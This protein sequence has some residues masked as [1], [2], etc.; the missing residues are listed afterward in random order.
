MNPNAC[1]DML[2]TL[3]VV[4][5][6]FIPVNETIASMLRNRFSAD[7]SA[8]IEALEFARVLDFLDKGDKS[9]TLFL[10]TN[11]AFNEQI[12]PDLFICLQYSRVQLSDLVLF[13]MADSAEYT[14][15]LTLRMFSYTRLPGQ[16]LHLTTNANGVIVFQLNN[17]TITE[18]NIPASNGVIHIIDRVLI[19]PNFDFG[20]CSEFVPT[21]PPPTTA[22]PTEAP[23]TEATTDSIGDTVTALP[24]PPL[25]EPGI[26][27]GENP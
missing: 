1:T 24:G 26:N 6:V 25:P 20:R 3:H 17:G 19:P 13:H 22:A 18:P 15:S 10:P 9:R 2:I 11:E 7:H 23:T 4:D 5:R 8:F 14:P 12:P 27:F 16:V 21:T